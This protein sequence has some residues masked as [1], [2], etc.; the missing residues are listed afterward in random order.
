ML[1]ELWFPCKILPS[2]SRPPLSARAQ[3]AIPVS[4]R[5]I[6]IR[7]D[8]IHDNYRHHKHE[9][10]YYNHNRLTLRRM[11]GR[12]LGFTGGTLD[13]LESIP[14]F[15]TSMQLKEFIDVLSRVGVAIIA[16]TSEFAPV[17][18][19]KS[20][21]C[22]VSQIHYILFRLTKK[23]TLCAMFPAP[24]APFPCSAAAS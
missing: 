16:T 22:L 21:K 2:T 6:S 9:H 11:S 17:C 12:G 14:G 8:I 15:R 20:P 7:N 19:T 1:W 4:N 3:K 18:N 5:P 13:K 10:H 23:S 24:W